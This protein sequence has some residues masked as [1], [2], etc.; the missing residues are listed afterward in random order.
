MGESEAER[1]KM[2]LE[3][4]QECLAVYS[5]KVDEAKICRAQLQR[6]IAHSKAEIADICSSLG[7]QS[8]KVSMLV[9]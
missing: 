7:E 9:I 1:D 5:R 6:T 3:I 8:V 2:I 4:E